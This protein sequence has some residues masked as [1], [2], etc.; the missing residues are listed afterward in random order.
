MFLRGSVLWIHVID[1]ICIV[2]CL[3]NATLPE[4]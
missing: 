4:V 3:D 1:A 2:A